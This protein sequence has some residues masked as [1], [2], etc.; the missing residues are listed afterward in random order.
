LNLEAGL[1]TIQG[2]HNEKRKK[3]GARSGLITHHQWSSSSPFFFIHQSGEFSHGQIEENHALK[4][5][6]HHKCAFAEYFY[7]PDILIESQNK[8]IQE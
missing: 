1:D 4:I 3:Q 6:F 7:Q 8:E 5:S 2:I